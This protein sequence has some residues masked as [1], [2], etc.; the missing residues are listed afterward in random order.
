MTSTLLHAATARTTGAQL[1][2]DMR[3]GSLLVFWSAVLMTVGAVICVGLQTVDTRLING[4]SV[5]LKPAKFFISLAIQFATVAW[6]MSLLPAAERA[7]RAVRWPILVMLFW[8][9]A[10]MA[11]LVFRASRAEA[12]HF[13]RSDAFA[14]IAYS[15]MGFG[16]VTLTVVAGYIG[17]RLWKHRRNGLWTEAASVGL[18]AGC[19]LGTLAG[20][21]LSAQTGHSVGGDVSDATGTGVF[22]WSTTGGDLRIA[23]FVGLHAAQIIPLAALSTKRSAVWGAAFACTVLTAGTFLL[24]VAGIPLLRAN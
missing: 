2:A 12:S 7:L 24:A 1:I 5:W 15:V 22:S 21:Y 11:Y 6:A 13:N 19:I 23:H 8:G 16:A 17:Y 3:E 9:W 18:I 20:I 14:L 10:E 4:V